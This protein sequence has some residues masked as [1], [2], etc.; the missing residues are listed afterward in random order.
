[1]FEAYAGRRRLA[2]LT[3]IGVQEVP[4]KVSASLDDL[5]AKIESLS[6]NLHRRPLSAA[7]KFRALHTI[8]KLCGDDVEAAA[9]K[10]GIGKATLRAYLQMRE[11]L[12]PEVL[13]KLD[14]GELPMDAA[15]ALSKADKDKQGDILDECGSD[16]K[17][18]RK[19]ASK[20]KKKRPKGPWVWD[21]NEQPLAIPQ[22]LFGKVLQLIRAS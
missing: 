11:N 13:D 2:A 17:D 1:M 9:K 19:E 22:H 18:I 10:A 20:D 21:E 4:C 3:Q 12:D 15:M 16:A 7:D 5:G 6:E 8:I 14:S